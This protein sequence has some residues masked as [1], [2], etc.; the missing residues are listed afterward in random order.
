MEEDF[1]PDFFTKSKDVF[2]HDGFYIWGLLRRH[3]A[4]VRNLG[5]K[6]FGKEERRVDLLRYTRQLEREI[7]RLEKN[8]SLLVIPQEP[9]S[10]EESEPR[11]LNTCKITKNKMEDLKIITVG[12]FGSTLPSSLS[13]SGEQ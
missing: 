12:D 13:S 8:T 10:L 3:L 4:Q 11:I 1:E 7:E 9:L 5:I 6:D 2:P